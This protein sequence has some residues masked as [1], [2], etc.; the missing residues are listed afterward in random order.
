MEK[1]NGWHNHATWCVALHL[2][3]TPHMNDSAIEICNQFDD[4]HDALQ[5]LKD[6]VYDNVDR[7]T[8]KTVA[9]WDDWDW[10]A[11]DLLHGYLQEVNFLEIVQ[12][13][14]EENK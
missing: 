4:E 7:N 11:A 10:L 5:E 1:Y 9:A 13:Y 14:R 12:H 2:S 8:S 6:Y 3:N